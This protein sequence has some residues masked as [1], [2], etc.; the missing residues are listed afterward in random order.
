MLVYRL[1]GKPIGV[2]EFLRHAVGVHGLRRLCGSGLSL[3]QIDPRQIDPRELDLDMGNEV[4]D[5]CDDRRRGEQ[6]DDPLTARNEYCQSQGEVRSR[7]YRKYAR[8][9]GKGGSHQ[10]DH[11]RGGRHGAS[12]IEHQRISVDRGERDL[13]T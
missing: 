4:G 12:V 2:Y 9:G 13:D 3:R 11:E 10:T 7:Y 5:P 6:T 8:D 1:V